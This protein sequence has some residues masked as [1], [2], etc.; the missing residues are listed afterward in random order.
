MIADDF[1][2]FSFSEAF[3]WRFELVRVLK[4]GLALLPLRVRFLTDA[5][6]KHLPGV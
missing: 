3:G 4:V 5:A 2:N 1:L 6:E